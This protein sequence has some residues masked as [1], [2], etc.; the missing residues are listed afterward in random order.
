MEPLC[1]VGGS[2]N[3]YSHYAKQY[4]GSS[5]KLKIELLY[6]PGFPLLGKYPKKMKSLSQKDMCI[7]IFTAASFTTAKTR[8]QPN[9]PSTDEWIKKMCTYTHTNTHTQA[10][11]HNGILFSH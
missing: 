2:V 6:D 9:C 7:P 11:S 3:W 4:G 8:K 5:K 1:T 10:L